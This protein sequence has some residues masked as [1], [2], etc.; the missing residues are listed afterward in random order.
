MLL[1][2]QELTFLSEYYMQQN[3]ASHQNDIFFES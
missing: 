1:E 2:S 3:Q